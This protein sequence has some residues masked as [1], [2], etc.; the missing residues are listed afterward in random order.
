MFTEVS[1]SK[2]CIGLEDLKRFVAQE[3][4]LKSIDLFEGR[5]EEARIDQQYF[6]DWMVSSSFTMRSS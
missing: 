2:R 3:K 6:I 4:A 1:M 5:E